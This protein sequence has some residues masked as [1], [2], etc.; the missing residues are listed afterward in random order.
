MDQQLIQ[1][2]RGKPTALILA[3]DQDAG[4]PDPEQARPAEKPMS[5]IVIHM[6]IGCGM[7]RSLKG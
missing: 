4:W 3:P 5:E 1:A 6:T 7:R 2:R